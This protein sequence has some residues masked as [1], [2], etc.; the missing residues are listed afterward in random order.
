MKSVHLNSR[1]S[2]NS[3]SKSMHVPLLA[4]KSV[5]SEFRIQMKPVCVCVCVCVTVLCVL[6][7]V[8]GMCACQ[9]MCLLACVLACRS[10]PECACAPECAGVCIHK[11]QTSSKPSPRKPSPKRSLS[12]KLSVLVAIHSA[13]KCNG[14]D[15]HEAS[16]F[17]IRPR[18]RRFGVV[19]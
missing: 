16:S 10:D 2:G 19:P 14:M 13:M 11:V 15:C 6:F 3:S 18:G 1:I 7:R 5:H 4:M 17:G 8:P 12:S 9:A